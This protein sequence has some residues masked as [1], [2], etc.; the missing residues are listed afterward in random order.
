VPCGRWST[1]V[2]CADRG[3][4]PKNRMPAKTQLSYESPNFAQAM[5]DL[6]LPPPWVLEL[7]GRG[8][9]EV[10]GDSDEIEVVE[11]GEFAL[12]GGAV[13][14]VEA[15][16]AATL[17]QRVTELYGAIIGRVDS[18]AAN[19]PVRLW[20]HI[21]A[22]HQPIEPRRD[23]YMVFNAGRYRAYAARF[24]GPNAFDREVP[25]ASGIG[26]DGRDLVVHCLSTRGEAIA[27]DNPRQ[28]APHRYS[29]RFGPLPP[30]FARAMLLPRRGLILVGGTASIRGEESLHR[31]SLPGQFAETLTNLASVVEAAHLQQGGAGDR[32]EREWL[33]HY[34]EVRVYYPR[35]ADGDKLAAMVRDVFADGC[36]IEMRRADLCR[37]ELLVEI[38]GV[39]R[40]NA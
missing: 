34:R 7:L 3:K 11:S 17:E 33:N 19:Q 1:T 25:T 36:R 18:L 29:A 32:S 4:V 31:A 30:C 24:G 13:R 35:P 28:V 22:I 20:N 21:P 2:D 26:Y 14:D 38:E 5:R 9:G 37:A 15:M 40:L 6:V 12:V 10:A 16:N 8:A 23:R 27:I 39:A